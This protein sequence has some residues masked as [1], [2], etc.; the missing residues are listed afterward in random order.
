MCNLCI[1]PINVAAT[2]GF[3]FEPSLFTPLSLADQKF[4]KMHTLERWVSEIWGGSAPD[5]YSRYG[6][7]APSQTLPTIPHAETLASLLH[8]ITP[9]LYTM[10]NYNRNRSDESNTKLESQPISKSQLQ[11][12]SR[13]LHQRVEFSGWLGPQGPINFP[14]GVAV[15]SE[16]EWSENS[17]TTRTS[18]R[19]VVHN[20]MSNVIRRPPQWTRP[21]GQPDGHF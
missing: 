14:A 20:V 3:G 11:T 8:T 10:C 12:R 2:Q 17:P 9:L 1:R 15:T 5:L 19:W 16:A 21:L 6:H 18:S 4:I 7:R 13:I